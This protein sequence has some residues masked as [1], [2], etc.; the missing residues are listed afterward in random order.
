[1]ETIQKL[2][3]MFTIGEIKI[4]KKKSG[5]KKSRNAFARRLNLSG[6][7]ISFGR[8]LK[9]KKKVRAANFPV[10]FNNVIRRM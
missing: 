2:Y 5:E 4:E 8:Y 7:L 1:M 6:I 10:F 9:K 3:V